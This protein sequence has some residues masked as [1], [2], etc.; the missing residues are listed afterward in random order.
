MTESDQVITSLLDTDLYKLFMHAAVHQHFPNVN[1][2][3][4]YTNRTPSMILNQEAISWLKYQ[5]NL[6]GNLTFSNEE[7]E[8][9]KQSLPQMP[10]A[11]TEYLKTFKLDP[12]NQIKYSNDYDNLEQFQL[13]VEGNW[14][15]TILYEIPILALVSE[16]YFKFVDTDWNY[17]GQVELAQI[18]CKELFNNECNFSEFGTRRRRS[19][20]VQDLV[21][22]SL[23]EY[24]E[25]NPSQ[26]KYLAGT[27]NVLLA[28]KYNLSAIG[29]VAHEWFMGVASISQDYINANKLSMDYWIQTFGT[30]Y[31]GLAL[32]DTFGTD[33]YLKAFIKPYTDYYTGVRQDSGDPEL[34]AEKIANH[35]NKL[36]YAPFSKVICFSDSLNIEKCINYK[37]KADQLGLK[38]TFGIGTFFTNDFKSSKNPS[39]KSQPLNIVIKLRKAGGYDSIKISDNLGKNMGNPEIVSNVK[40]ILGYEE[41]QWEEGDETKRWNGSERNVDQNR[42]E[43][44]L[45]KWEIIPGYHYLLQEIYLKV[46]IP[47]QVRWLSII[48]FKNGIDKYWRSSRQYAISKQ[49]KDQI[50]S[51]VFLLLNEQ[52]NQL[53]IQNAHSIAR[54]SRFDFPSEWP[55]LFDDVAKNLE[56]FVFKTNDIISTNNLLIILNRIIKTISVV[57]IGRSRHAMQAK[58]PLVVNILIKLYQKFFQLWTRN[59]DLSLM[60]VCY[61]CLK[62]LRRIIPEGYEQPHKNQ[63]VVEFLNTTVDHLQLLIDNHD[64]YSSDLLERYV[65]CYCKLYVTLITTNPTSFILLPSCQKILNTFISLLYQKAEYI[66]NSSEENDFWEILALKAFNIYKHLVNYIYRKGAITL[67]QKNDKIEV[68][69]SLNKLTNEF[70]TPDFIKQFCD[71]IITWYLRLKPSD[72]ESWTLEPEEWC[73]EEFSKQW[74]YQ[75]R[76]C[77]ENF[78]QDLMQYFKDDLTDFVINKISNGLLESGSVDK[79]LIRDSILS[80]FQLSAYSIADNVNFDKLLIEVFIPEGMKNDL[81]ENKIIKRRVCLIIND[82][83]G[84]QCNRESR[85]EIYKLLLNFLQIS[86]DKVVKF[87]AIQ[88][89]RTVIDD[90]DF[91]KHDFQPFLNLFVE[92]LLN[93]LDELKLTESKLYIFDTLAVLIQRCNPLVDHQ[94]LINIL[95]IIPKYWEFSTVNNEHILKNSLL[96]VLKSLTISLNEN[97]IETHS[98]SIPLIRNCCGSDLNDLYAICSEDGYELW[99]SL[100]QYCPQSQLNNSEILNLFDLI[101]IGLLNSTE[102]LPIILSILR[103]YSLYSPNLFNSEIGLELLKILSGYLSTMRDDSFQIFISLMDILILE[104]YQSQEFITNL[105]NS[106]MFLN[107]VAY[108]IDENQSIISASKLLI[109]LS[110]LGKSSPEVLFKLFEY[111]S[112]IDIDQ[113]F[114]IWLQYFKSIGNPRNKKINLLAL[115]SIVIYG[116]PK[117]IPISLQIYSE[118]IRK[119]FLFLEEV[120]ESTTGVCDAYKQDFTYEDLDDYAYLDPDIKPHGEKIRYEIL[121]EKSD[122]VYT[123]NLQ[124]YLKD[125]IISLKSQLQ[126]ADFNQVMNL[127][128]E[129]SLEKLKSLV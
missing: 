35:Y 107:M 126:P 111:H 24:A 62:N 56:E 55:S 70:F 3:Y 106:N 48:C 95:I 13:E 108:V 21:V 102:I 82:W 88:S 99:L 98:I 71:L 57:R 7:I 114:K 113:L 12:Q 22:K 20:K 118:V 84:I 72:L 34:Y 36:G 43:D 44:Q 87:S 41:R 52:N 119:S 5:I 115:I 92:L 61:L 121:L 1:V 127:N 124:S 46:E 29:T 93:L 42:A 65:K 15:Q 51:R 125:A 100:L 17:D 49:E 112:N 69:N 11:Y 116:I 54:I 9:I 75:I 16:A 77:A 47:L 76:P 18:K 110:R 8:Y 74:E 105:V 83:V 53:T 10:L 94:T 27:S 109:I 122:P 117:N 86:N 19:F 59:M 39:I 129:Y 89:L 103:S 2:V 68:T 66:Y 73:N 91:N 90:W 28:K 25:L 14:D 128:D 26:S 40:R 23:K 45:K 33:S 81:I 67:K 37:H 4:K 58:A 64:K 30:H 120:N 101:S 96:R 80:T 60:E 50:R 104:N 63:D 85:V 123:V 79:I 32:T 31:A 78:F 97:S 38:A 6:L